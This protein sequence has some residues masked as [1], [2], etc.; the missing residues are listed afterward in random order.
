MIST[1]RSGGGAVGGDLP[2]EDGCLLQ[3][4]GHAALL[5]DGSESSVLRQFCDQTEALAWYAN[6]GRSRVCRRDD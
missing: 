1:S 2:P 3:L 5:P 4:D 6:R